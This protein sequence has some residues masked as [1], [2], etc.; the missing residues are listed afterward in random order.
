MITKST[1][2]LVMIASIGCVL[3]SLGGVVLSR[4]QLVPSDVNL[5]I[6]QF[7]ATPPADAAAAAVRMARNVR[8][9]VQHGVPLDPVKDVGGDRDLDIDRLAPIDPVSTSDAV[10][11]G[12]VETGEA[13]LSADRTGVYSEF[14]VRADAVWND[15][16]PSSK[17]TP[18]ASNALFV[19]L[20]LG[21]L[22][23]FGSG[24]VGRFIVN[25]QALP[26]IGE[27]YVFFLRRELDLQAF[28][29]VTAYRVSDGA[30]TPLDAGGEFVPLPAS[31]LAELEGAVRNRLAGERP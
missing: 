24:E 21:G 11:V 22:V 8:F 6:A 17:I 14:Q 7:D 12:T 13:F 19:A 29:I 27:R 1:R 26:R 16:V 10:V 20:R 23:R 4:A 5:P 18:L 31:T 9:N 25:Q 15:R 2:S 28:A 30:V 3:A